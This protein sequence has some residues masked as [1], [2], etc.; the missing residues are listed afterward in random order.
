MRIIKRYVR[1]RLQRVIRSE[2]AGLAS[3]LDAMAEVSPACLHLAVIG[4]SLSPRA[5]GAAFEK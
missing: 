5:I 4:D 3:S 1:E 2:T